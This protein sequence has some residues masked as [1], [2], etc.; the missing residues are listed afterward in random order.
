MINHRGV[1]AFPLQGSGGLA[2]PFLLGSVAILHSA[3]R[4]TLANAQIKLMAPKSCASSFV[5]RETTLCLKPGPSSSRFLTIFQHGDNNQSI[6]SCDETIR[7]AMREGR[8]KAIKLQCFP[9]V[10]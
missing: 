6:E 2:A 10:S 4:A 3:R 7:E 9:V 8:V 5:L 1:Q